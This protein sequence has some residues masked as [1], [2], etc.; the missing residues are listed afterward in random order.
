MTD[1][2]SR[3]R[4]TRGS[5]RSQ[6][7]TPSKGGALKAVSVALGFLLLGGL[8]LAAM[9]FAGYVVHLDNT[10]REQF[11]GKRWALPARVYARPLEI[12]A[13]LALD[14]DNLAQQLRLLSYRPVDQPV[15]PGTFA[16]QGNVI[17]LYTRRFTFWDG[18]EEPRLVRMTFGQGKVRSLATLDGSL[19]S[20]LL[21]LEPLEI[22]G[23]YPSHNEDRILVRREGIPSV[24]VDALIAVEDRK[25]HEHHGIDLKGIFR[26]FV[27][28][29]R[30]GRTVQGGSTLTQQLVKN[31]FLSNERTLRRKLNEIIMAL[32]LDWHYDKDE[33]LEA[34]ANE[35]YLGQD[36]NRAI[37][38][39]GLASWFY[40]GRPLAELNL[41]HVALL[42]GLVKGPSLY[43]PR[44][45]PQRATERRALV[46]DVMVAQGLIS[47]EDAETAK[48][49]P[50]GVAAKPSGGITRYPAFLE[51]V[52]RQLKEDYREEDLTTEGLRI[53][54]TLDPTSQAH[55]EDAVTDALPVLESRHREVEAGSLQAAVVV[56]D[57]QNGEVLALVGGRDVQL[58]GFNRV[59]DARRPVG[60]L[61][62][63]AVFLTALEFPRIY[64]LASLL[65]DTPLNHRIGGKVWSPQNYSKS[66]HGQVLLEDAL[67]YS[68][69]VPTARIALDLDPARIVQTLNRLGIQRD[70]PAFPSLALGAADMSPLEIAQLYETF[71]SGGF[72]VPLRVIRDVT[73][74]D[75]QPLERYALSVKKVIEPGPA[76]LITRAMQKVVSKG[77]AAA[78]SQKISRKFNI[79]GKTGT[80]DDLRDSW[81]AGFSGN[82]MA[83]VW[84]GRDDFKPA[85]LSGSSGALRVWMDVMK[86]LSLEPLELSPPPGIQTVLID[87]A[88]GLLA[89][90]RCQDAV[91]MPF[92][93]GSAPRDLAPC[94][95]VYQPPPGYAGESFPNATPPP[96]PPVVTESRGR[97]VSDFFNRLRN[98]ESR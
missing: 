85:G 57:S 49:K 11:E 75:G 20:G 45:H 1:K 25:F 4:P 72:R 94:S 16:R 46:L 82:R 66:Y 67:A 32:L 19:D 51:L 12:Y 56:V 38:G 65:D 62:K 39:L 55:V 73:T 54:T 76:Y 3:T 52:Q 8:V 27:A 5:G 61:L 37:H 70:L 79:A 87:P 97:E 95:A 30:A 78:M 93:A 31:Y 26:A 91:P 88:T 44:R 48:T 15:G 22:A 53:F 14:P 17:D 6:H 9:T 34:Y 43:D 80:T 96:S 42:V 35:V 23:I 89:D 50:L 86:D 81:F 2:N 60:S 28:N 74:A 71:A 47:R 29:L 92:I 13:G 58:A 21:R 59:L 7:K 83:V 69:N 41:H 98:N 40:F 10:I 84:L 68:Y 64:T 18:A 24:L 90:D 77:T 36:G 63:P 33:I